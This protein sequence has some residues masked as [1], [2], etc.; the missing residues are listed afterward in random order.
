MQV[1]EL[2]IRTRG[3]LNRPHWNYIKTANCIIHAASGKGLPQDAE[4]EISTIFN[5]G[6]TFWM[7]ASEV[8]NY[9]LDNSPAM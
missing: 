1:K 8:G 3:F 5:N 2:N 6:I 7:N 4:N 9:S